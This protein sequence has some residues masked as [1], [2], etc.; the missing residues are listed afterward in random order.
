VA[1]AAGWGYHVAEMPSPFPGMDPYLESPLDWHSFHTDLIVEICRNLQ[2]QLSPTYVA[3][4]EQRIV[5]GALEIQMRPDVHVHESGIGGPSRGTSRGGA[6]VLEEI[7]VPDLTVPQRY[8]V[9]R[10]ARGQEVITVV[11]VLS[12]WNKAGEGL[13]DYRENQ[14]ELLL[15]DA[16]LVEIDLLRR[17]Q[18][19][20]ALPERLTPPSDYRVCVHRARRSGFGLSRFGVREPLPTIPIPLRGDDPDV[21]LDLQHV[22]TTCYHSGAY[23]LDLDYSAPPEPPLSPEDAGWAAGLL[24]PAE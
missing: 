7:E 11:E 4:S 3:R 14:R 22:F 2:P 5:L 24:H 10:N 13:R 20:I 1:L 21:L 9:I 17:G 16:S 18:H 15:S 23:A 8:V 6:A 19:A 12:P